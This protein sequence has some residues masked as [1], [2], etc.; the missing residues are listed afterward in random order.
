[1]RLSRCGKVTHNLD[2]VITGPGSSNNLTIRSSNTNGAVA[3]LVMGAS[4][5]YSGGTIVN[6]L[7]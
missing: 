3:D 2:D 1:M 5:T 4:N 7:P 6:G